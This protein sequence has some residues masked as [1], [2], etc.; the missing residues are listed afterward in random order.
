MKSDMPV[1]HDGI[2]LQHV[3][4]RGGMG[5]VYQAVDHHLD[6]TLAVKSLRD[7]RTSLGE[8]S[9]LLAEA[10]IT[11][12]VSHPGVVPV[13]DVRD[14][15]DGKPRIYLQLL[16]G[17][18]WKDYLRSPD[19]AK[20]LSGDGDPIRLHVEVLIQ[21][22]A[23][24]HAAH[25]RQIVHRDLKPGNV[26]LTKDRSAYL[27]DWGLAATL[28]P[29]ADARLP[30]LA[31]TAPGAGT[32]QYMAPEMY[33]AEFGAIEPRTDVYLLGG[34]LYEILYGQAPHTGV[35]SRDA[36][37][38]RFDQ[39][40][41]FPD[42]AAV[43]LVAIA[44][45]CLQVRGADRFSS[46]EALRRE[47]ASW[48]GHY[49]SI[50]LADEGAVARGTE[51]LPDR[52]LESM[53]AFSRAIRGWKDNERAKH[54]LSGLLTDALQEAIRRRDWALSEWVLAYVKATKVVG[55]E[56]LMALEHGLEVEREES[57]QRIR[58]A[59]D[60]AAYQAS[61]L[62]IAPR[63][64]AGVGAVALLLAGFAQHYAMG[65]SGVSIVATS[66]IVGL[67][68]S[69]IG[70]GWRARSGSWVA[71][72]GSVPVMWA[73]VGQAVLCALVAVTSSPEWAGIAWV[74]AFLL[75]GAGL[76]EWIS[77]RPVR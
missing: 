59:A 20:Q 25:V 53:T 39:P 18:P 41:P 61:W 70:L 4:G 49:D 13:F 3:L 17:R 33:N 54:S 28:D 71:F 73:S 27:L 1:E 63:A 30:T 74:S 72:E 46:A 50:R 26:I 77:G 66:V 60:Q 23:A 12:A 14:G 9:A 55:S 10:R 47:L 5:V 38:S 52:F 56:R 69:M 34:L 16:E 29:E 51:A 31:N 43:E 48:L 22:C 57:D 76:A 75:A 45:R 37:P 65:T 7:D 6:R 21:V 8:V 35:V 62:S 32:P 19:A 40:I 44:R 36:L 67:G 15:P 24:V 58:R 11:G 68:V 64:V 2:E 42:H